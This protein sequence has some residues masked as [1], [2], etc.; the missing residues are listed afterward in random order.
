[1]D[2]AYRICLTVAVLS[3]GF[4][5][6][7]LIAYMVEASQNA[8][9]GELAKMQAGGTTAFRLALLGWLGA[10]VLWIWR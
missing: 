10:I 1:M 3:T 8:Q 2:I 5:F 6:L 4:F 7:I 9:S